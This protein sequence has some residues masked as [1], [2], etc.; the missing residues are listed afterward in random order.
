MTE[1]VPERWGRGELL[2]AAEPT[3]PQAVVAAARRHPGAIA[4]RQGRRAMT[5]A[6]L[7]ASAGGLARTL[8][9][10]GVG[11]EATVGVCGRRR[12]PTKAA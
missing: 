9:D 10:L 8:C 1:A 6:E 3:V 7:V 4:V 12:P 5:Y 11:P 2:A